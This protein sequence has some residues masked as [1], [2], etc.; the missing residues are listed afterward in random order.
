[1]AAYPERWRLVYGPPSGGTRIYQRVEAN[2][3]LVSGS[4]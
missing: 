1:V 2:G 4:K 3:P